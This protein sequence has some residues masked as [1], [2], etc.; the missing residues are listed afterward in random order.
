MFSL[1]AFHNFKIIVLP[2]LTSKL[3]LKLLSNYPKFKLTLSS[4]WNITDGV[5]V[6]ASDWVVQLFVSFLS[7]FV[8][9]HKIGVHSSQTQQT[10][11]NKTSTSK[12]LKFWSGMLGTWATINQW[13]VDF[14]PFHRVKLAVVRGTNHIVVWLEFWHPHTSRYLEDTH[15]FTIR[16]SVVLPRSVIDAVQRLLQSPGS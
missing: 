4:N 10:K 2:R 3:Q 14:S 11:S 7:L 6:A 5:E 8:D 16:A 9:Y 1:L 12:S 15:A 13:S